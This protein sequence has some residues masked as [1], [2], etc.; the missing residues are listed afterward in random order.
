MKLYFSKGA[1][2]LACRIII[3]ELGLSS[4]YESVELH[5][6]NKQTETGADFFRINLK[7]AVPTLIT[8][9]GNTLTENVVILQYL[10]EKA[11][12]T[13]LL[14]PASNFE[15]YRVLEWLNYV[16]T[17]L[18]K[19]CGSLFNPNVPQEIKEKVFIPLIKTKLTHIDKHLEQHNFLAGSQFTLPD[20]YLFVILLWVHHLKI[21]GPWKNLMRYH[22]GLVKRAAIKQSLQDEGLVL[23]HL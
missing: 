9:D 4:E 21:Q 20:A 10:A 1:C 22:T 6:K 15:H 16:A 2:S 8:D 3:N 12:A 19:T 18:H 13:E 7:G 11:N 23:S 5:S 14:P 17:E